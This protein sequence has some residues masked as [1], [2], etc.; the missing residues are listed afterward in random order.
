MTTLTAED[1]V[2]ARRTLLQ[3]EVDRF[4]SELSHDRETVGIVLFGSMAGGALRDYSDIDLVVVKDTRAP[5]LERLRSVRRQLK[6]KV[7]TDFLVYTREEMQRL[8]SSRPFVREEI[9]KRGKVL[10]ERER[11]ALAQLCT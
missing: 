1:A 4:V 9:M 8:W 3:S 11:G 2:E 6:P 10:Y 5:F 7:A